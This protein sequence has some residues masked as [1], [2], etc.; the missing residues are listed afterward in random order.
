MAGSHRRIQVLSERRAGVCLHATSLP[1][2][3]ESGTLGPDAYFFVDWMIKAGLRVWQVLPLGPTH[4]DGSP[5]QCLSAHAGNPRLICRQTLVRD[6]WIDD[7]ERRGGAGDLTLFRHAEQ[8][9]STLASNEDRLAYDRFIKHHAYWLEDYALFVPLR[10]RFGNVSWCDWPAALRDREPH[11]L[12]QMRHELQQETSAIRFQQFVFFRQWLALK[13]YANA[14]GI[15]ILGDLPIFVAHDSADVWANRKQFLLDDKGWPTVVAGVP[16]DYFSA[17]GQRWGNPLYDWN[18]MHDDGFKW[19]FTRFETQLAICDLI[20]IDHFRGFQANWEIPASCPT[21][22]EGRWVKAPG[23]ALFRA[24]ANKYGQLPLVAEDLGVIT[25]E[26]TALRRQFRLPGMKILQFA[27]DG[28]PSNPYLPHAHTC[29]SIVYTGTHDNAT[30]LGWFE[31]LPLDK[32]LY[33]L[34]YLGNPQDTIPWPLIR[35]AM[36]SVSPLALIPMQD[37]LSLDDTHRMNRP[38]TTEGNWQWRLSWSQVPPD[39]ADRVRTLVYLYGR[40]G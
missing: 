26:V 40:G 1:G 6:G 35:A 3:E 23:K 32:Q 5:Y 39:V 34:D 12:A 4:V 18:A 36:G 20:R 2:A 17:T 27:F 38:G 22:I 11:A 9:F 10:E 19:W 33:C 25:R 8:R 24:V 30:T 29:D 16:P 37:F 21:A 31:S 15:L 7:D 28:N 14:H 13:H